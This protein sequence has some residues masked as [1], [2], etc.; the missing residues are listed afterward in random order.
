METYNILKSLNET[1]IFEI[2]RI[3]YHIEKGLI[4]WKELF[5][6]KY[7]ETK[8]FTTTSC[9]ARIWNHGYGKQCS[10]NKLSS[11]CYCKFHTE[12]V[13]KYGYWWLGN[14]NEELQQNPKHYNGVI[15]SW[16]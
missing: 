13:N 11:G 2:N 3:H 15:H 6:K 10:H 7:K 8:K 9:S 14:Y 5:S 12:K 16:N 4:T 1:D